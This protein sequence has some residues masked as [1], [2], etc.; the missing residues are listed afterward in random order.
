MSTAKAEKD[1]MI[2]PEPAVRSPTP[3]KLEGDFDNAADEEKSEKVT[4]PK[5]AANERK[6]TSLA[7]VPREPTGDQVDK[8]MKDK[9]SP[10]RK[11]VPKAK[12][13]GKMK[14]LKELQGEG[15]VMLGHMREL[16]KKQHLFKFQIPF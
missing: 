5:K 9:N 4:T 6:R 14:K 16:L 11:R 12:S 2:A 10:K 13:P 15:W 3:R 8:E 1:L 7:K